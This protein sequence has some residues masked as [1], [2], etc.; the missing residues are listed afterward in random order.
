MGSATELLEVEEIERRF[1]WVETF[2]GDGTDDVFMR[3]LLANALI[4]SGGYATSDDW[5]AEWKQSSATILGEKSNRFFASI[6]HSV[7][8]LERD[9]PPQ[10][11]AIGT[12]PSS[13]SAMA[14]AP[15]GIVNAGHPVAAAAQAT[16]IASLVHVTDNA[17]CQDA[18]A[19]VAASI[20][21]ALAP[22]ATVD[23]IIDAA[24]KS[25]RGW[26]AEEMRDL[27]VAAL[28]LA[29]SATDFGTFRTAYH[30][31]F[32]RSVICDSRETIPA[33]FGIVWMAKGDPSVATAMGANFGR[34]CDTIA[35]M[36]GGICGAL[37]GVTPSNAAV[38]NQ[39]SPGVRDAQRTLA[40]RLCDLAASKANA[41]IAAWNNRI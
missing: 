30:Q 2:E 34:D 15:V 40:A 6:L 12:M 14:I 36:A 16:E 25:V 7:A 26:S 33:T 4:K 27:I 9:Y 38:I 20:A 22:G 21:A 29:R 19:A 24:L 32:R 41:E 1:G 5:A 17:F 3:D 23:S 28:D 18:A 39:L 35:C 37:Q 10:L 8:K 13:T 11:I 31:R